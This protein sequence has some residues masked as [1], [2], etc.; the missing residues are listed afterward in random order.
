MKIGKAFRPALAER[1][2]QSVDHLQIARL[3]QSAVEGQSRDRSV[4]LPL[5]LHRR[6][7]GLPQTRPVQAGA[8]QRGRLA[9]GLLAPQ[10]RGSVGEELARVVETAVDQVV[11]EPAT[12]LCGQGAPALQLRVGLIVSRE[13]RVRDA[14]GAARRNRLLQTVGPVA[15]AAQQT[16][17]HQAR[18]AD[19]LFDVQVHRHR[20]AELQEIGEAQARGTVRPSRLGGGEAGQLGV[21][22][23]QKHDVA[24]RLAEVDRLSG[25]LRRRRLRLEQMHGSL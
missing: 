13:D 19:H 2:D 21:G 14:A 7:I 4:R 16:Q 22:G 20:M 1:I 23:R 17:Y 24:R 6:E 25:I 5:P 8:H 11:P 10:Q 15:A 9:P 3:D 18:A 12:G